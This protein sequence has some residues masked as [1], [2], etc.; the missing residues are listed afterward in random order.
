MSQSIEAPNPVD[1]TSIARQLI[2]AED[3]VKSVTGESLTGD[4][5]DLP[6]L[7][8]VIDSRRVEREATYSLQSLGIAFGKV[9][10]ENTS[11]YDW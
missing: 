5:D 9:L 3:L 10:V 6:L 11:D 4:E 7:Q 8:R 1:V 2:H